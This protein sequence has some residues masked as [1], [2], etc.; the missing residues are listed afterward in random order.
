MIK[1]VQIVDPIVSQVQ[2]DEFCLTLHAFNLSDE[3]VVQV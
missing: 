3:V 1:L 2:I